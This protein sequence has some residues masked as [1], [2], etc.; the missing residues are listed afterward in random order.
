MSDSVGQLIALSAFQRSVGR[1]YFNLFQPVCVS[2]ERPPPEVVR[3]YIFIEEGGVL[4]PII[5]RSSSS[6][7][8]LRLRVVGWQK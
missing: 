3:R 6:I 8:I 5:P 2:S 4:I 7:I 1:D